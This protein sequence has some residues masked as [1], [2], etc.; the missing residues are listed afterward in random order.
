MEHKPFGHRPNRFHNLFYDGD[1]HTQLATALMLAKKSTAS[2]ELV[3]AIEI[4]ENQLAKNDEC[5]HTVTVVQA[6]PLGMEA[7]FL[8]NCIEQCIDVAPANLCQTSTGHLEL[9]ITARGDRKGV[10]SMAASILS[11]GVAQAKAMISASKWTFK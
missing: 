9:T 7:A 2:Q 6:V 10:Q 8:M 11:Y 4:L 3:A 1:W 5:I